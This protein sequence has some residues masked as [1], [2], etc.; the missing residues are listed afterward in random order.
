MIHYQ[1][2]KQQLLNTCQALARAGYLIGTGGNVSIR[3]DGESALAITPS[4]RDYLT[5]TVDDI[6]VLSFDRQ[7]LEGTLKPSI[8][9][10]R[11]SMH[12][13]SD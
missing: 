4:G 13:V 12:C 8:F 3:I 11:N 5:M 1:P 2:F 10:L 9:F 7:P 6:C